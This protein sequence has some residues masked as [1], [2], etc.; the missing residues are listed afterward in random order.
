MSSVASLS[1]VLRFLT[2]AFN[3]PDTNY[4][5]GDDNIG[6]KVGLP[7]GLSLFWLLVI[8]GVS[9]YLKRYFTEKFRKATVEPEVGVLDTKN[10]LA[11][12]LP[13]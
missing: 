8:V 12:V 3:I 6:L 2:D 4:D 7:V 9:C 5:K 11:K 1:G 13:Q 10:G